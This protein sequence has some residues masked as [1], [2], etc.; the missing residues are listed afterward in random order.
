MART[1]K[2]RFDFWQVCPDEIGRQF[3]QAVLSGNFGTTGDERLEGSYYRL[4]EVDFSQRPILGSAIKIHMDNIPRK[5]RIGE[6]DTEPLGLDEREG[7]VG[8]TFFLYSPD[9]D[10]LISQRNRQGVAPGALAFLLEKTSGVQGINL[11]P[12]FELEWRRRLE[13]MQ[14]FRRLEMKVA[15]PTAGADT[16]QNWGAKT[17]ALLG[18]HY[19]GRTVEI[20]ISVGRKRKEVSLSAA[21]V[22]ETILS[23]CGRRAGE[24]KG[25]EVKRLLVTGRTGEDEPLETLDILKERLVAEADVP[26]LNRELCRRSLRTA[27]RRTYTEHETELQRYRAP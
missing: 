14:V 10:T 23:L 21:K 9:Y 6:R 11:L 2:V 4:V 18:E 16:Y 15:T 27:I 3:R 7:I 13:R 26:L 20:K 19:K 12:I 25:P 5:T 17:A 1:K 8:E 22:R 24:G